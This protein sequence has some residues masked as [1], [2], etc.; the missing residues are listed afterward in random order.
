[1]A[2]PVPIPT[3]ESKYTLTYDDGVKGFPSFYTYYPDWIQGM[4]NYLY[5]FK[6]GNIYRHNTNETRNNY[7]GEDFSSILTSVFNDQPLENKLFKTLELESDASWSATADSDQQIGNFINKDEFKLKEGNYFGY[8]RA[9]NS[10]PAS[11][12]QYPL[13]SANGIG[14][15]TTVNTLS[16]NNVIINFSTDPY[17]NIGTILSIGDYLYIKSGFTNQVTLIGEVKDKVLDL[18]NGTNYLIVDTTITD[19]AGTLIGNLPPTS[20]NYYFFIKNGTAE[21]HGILGHYAV[22]TLTNNNTGAVEL[23]AVGSEVMKSFP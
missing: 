17:I 18:Q 23:F 9:Q 14:N 10:E 15:N 6:G 19:S 12:A 1:M 22:F 5:T 4:N 8:L 11:A 7:Y 3:L 2:G 16:P 20:P 21:S 13:R